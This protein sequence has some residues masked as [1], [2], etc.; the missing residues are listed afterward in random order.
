MR[1]LIVPLVAVG[2]VFGSANDEPTEHQMRSAFELSLAAKVRSALEFVAETGGAEATDKVRR[3]GTDRFNINGFQKRECTRNADG[4]GHVCAF[5][6]QIGLVNG[7]L[8][9]TMRGRFYTAPDGLIYTP[10]A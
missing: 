8:Q 7:A 2:V 9:G 6:V 3:N 5:T 10:E 4:P 1:L